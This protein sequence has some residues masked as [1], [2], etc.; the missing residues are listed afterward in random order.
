[1][2]TEKTPEGENLLELAEKAT[3]ELEREPGTIGPWNDIADRATSALDAVAALMSARIFPSTVSPCGADC[4]ADFG[5][6]SE[7]IPRVKFGEGLAQLH[8]R[9]QQAHPALAELLRSPHVLDRVRLAAES[10]ASVYAEDPAVFAEAAVQRYQV[11]IAQNLIGVDEFEPFATAVAVNIP[12]L[13][14][15]LINALTRHSEHARV[16]LERVV[17]EDQEAAERIAAGRRSMLENFF[18]QHASVVFRAADTATPQ[19]TGSDVLNWLATAT[20]ADIEKYAEWR[21]QYEQRVRADF[22]RIQSVAS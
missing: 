5:L 4:V 8:R 14:A 12:A 15:R 6:Y 20:P 16:E 1:M 9:C 19:V 13:R 3:A 22:D 2:K 17:R 7:M 18:R 11:A 10:T 21:E